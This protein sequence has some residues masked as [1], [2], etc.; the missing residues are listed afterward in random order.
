MRIK[1][2]IQRTLLI[3]LAVAALLPARAQC[4]SEETEWDFEGVGLDKV[5]DGY[6]QEHRLDED[7]F[8]MGWYD[9]VSGESWFF[10]EDKYMAAGSMYKLPLNMLYTDKLAAG[11][12]AESDLVGGYSVET[13]MYTSIVYSDNTTAQALRTGLGLNTNEYRDLLAQYSGIETDELPEEYYTENYMS[14][15]FMI[16]TLKYLYDN[17]EHYSQLIEDL[18]LAHPG[19]Y[20]KKSEGEYEIAHKYGS[21]EGFLNDCAIVYTPRPFLIVVFTKSVA[22]NETVLS[23]LCQMMTAYSL[24]LDGK[25]REAAEAEQQAAEEEAERDRLAAEEARQRELEVQEQAKAA[26]EA[27]ALEAQQAAEEEA[28][29]ESERLTSEKRSRIIYTVAILCAAAVLILL[30]SRLRK[31]QSGRKCGRWVSVLL[32]LGALLIIAFFELPSPGSGA[33]IAAPAETA[34][35][36]PPPV[37]ETDAT[38]AQEE[39]EE[40]P[41][42]TAEPQ[43]PEKTLWTLSF[44]G[45][46]TIGTLHEWQGMKS[47]GNMLYVV[48]EDY[49]YPLSNVREYFENDDFTM[50]NLEGAFTQLTDAKGK[51]YRF[52]APEEYAQVLT[53]GGVE[54]VTLANNHSGDYREQGLADTK[55][56]LEGQNILYTDESTPIIMTL[57]GGLK[58]GVI[59]FNAVEIDLAVGDV[60]GYMER[61]RPMYEQCEDEGCGLIIAYIHWGWEYRTEPESWMVEMAHE[62]VELGC[63]MVLGSHPHVLQRMEYYEGVPIF[64]SLGNFCYGGHSDPQDKDSVIVRQQVLSDGG[65]AYVLGELEIMPCRISTADSVNDFCPTP[66]E[67]GSGEYLRVM[68][69]LGVAGE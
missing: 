11:E 9:T 24:Y 30:F 32:I 42:Q 56:A 20:F 48:G 31:D 61:I 27:E 22:N 1:T 44:A 28:G 50:V 35:Q 52:R 19:R 21:F 54:A 55:G 43:A 6:M 39:P 25:A 3:F 41:E 8:A 16:N 15:R 13:A 46:C 14:P 5:I 10:N 38:L 53:A 18:K 69:K 58:L 7:N 49:A 67:P 4:A 12:I 23:D 37:L 2:K 64:Y 40:T 34:A 59:S 68:E 51:D 65:N 45:D 47:S 66:Y 29:A 33:D 63:D 57:E 26:A 60:V 62:L 17:S 36:T